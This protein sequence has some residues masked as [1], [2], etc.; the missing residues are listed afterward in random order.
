MNFERN[1]AMKAVR[2]ALGVVGMTSL[3]A[4]PI[5]AQAQGWYAGAGIGQADYDVLSEKDTSFK[6]FAGYS[7][8][9]NVAAEFGYVDLGEAE[10][11][12]GGASASVSAD[13]LEA[14]VVGVL[15]VGNNVSLLGRVGLFN[16]DAEAKATIPGFGSASGSDSGTDLTYG[17]GAQFDLQKSFALRAEYQVYDVDGDDVNNLGVSGVFRF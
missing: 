10:V 2:R 11:S 16:W 4:G 15:P 6:L 7:F 8:N 5:A 3:A 9:P 13:G 1:S 12:G 17:F 14:T